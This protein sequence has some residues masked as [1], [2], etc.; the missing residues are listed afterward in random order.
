LI[1]STTCCRLKGP[2]VLENNG[3]GGSLGNVLKRCRSAL[4]GQIGDDGEDAS[5][6]AT[7]LRK[8]SVFDAGR[9][10]VTESRLKVTLWAR[11]RISCSKLQFQ[12]MMSDSYV[13][14]VITIAAIYRNQ[15]NL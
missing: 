5:C 8:G 14:V 6:I 15:S 10:M 1:L 2:T 7:P 13:L 9:V 12:M 11:T 3:W 4:T